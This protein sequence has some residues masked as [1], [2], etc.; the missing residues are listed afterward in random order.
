M[1]DALKPSN[2][3][4]CESQTLVST[5]QSRCTC[6]HFSSCTPLIYKLD[7]PHICYNLC[8]QGNANG[9]AV[10]C[11]FGLKL[12]RQHFQATP[13]VVLTLIQPMADHTEGSL[14]SCLCSLKVLI[15][16]AASHRLH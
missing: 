1:T 9:V 16:M 5:D 6:Q 14:E 12:N 4:G 10:Q 2:H 3:L 15:R 13:H 11:E 8:T 7:Q